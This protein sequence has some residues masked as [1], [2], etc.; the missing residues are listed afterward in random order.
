[1]PARQRNETSIG[2]LGAG[3]MGAAIARVAA[4]AGWRVRLFD[5]RPL[6]LAAAYRGVEPAARGRVTCTLQP[7]GFRACSLVIEAV[8]E[9]AAVKRDVLR[10]VEAGVGEWALFA[11][12]TS[13]VP[14]A[15]LA[16]GLR[17]PNRLAGLHFVS[18]ADRAPL[19]EIV[20]APATAAPFLERAGEFAAALGKTAIVVRDGPG[21]YTTRILAPYLACGLDLVSSGVPIA[22]IDAAGREAGFALGPLELLDEIG[23]DVAAS[24]AAVLAAG[25][26]GHMTAHPGFK[27]ML[28]NGRLGRKVGQG[29][30]DYKRRRKRP[31]RDA[32]D[33]FEFETVVRPPR[34]EL[35]HRLLGA[36]SAEARRCLE[37][38]VIV[39]PEDGDRGAVLGL[40]YPASL[41]GPFGTWS[42]GR[43][44]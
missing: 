39:S 10:A 41:G 31:D 18:P 16:A 1:M 42:A 33:L 7:E 29:F 28:Q 37:D 17:Y 14:I 4:A 12:T 23:L 11:S 13:T 43:P 21:F 36:M 32:E 20:R 2:I 6:A 22:E 19:V 15:H 40:G 3:V 35:A 30:Y 25:L 27:L 8:V 38:G 24:A 26:S 5:L 9:D 44:G 34:P